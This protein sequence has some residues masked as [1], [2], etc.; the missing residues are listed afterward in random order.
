VVSVSLVRQNALRLPVPNGCRRSITSHAVFNTADARWLSADEQ[1]EEIA[2]YYAC[3]SYVD[4]CLGVMLDALTESGREDRTIVCVWGDHGM[5][6]GEHG[7]FR[8]ATVFDGATRVPFL[9]AAPGTAKAGAACTRPT[10]LIDMYPTLAE[11]CGLPAPAGLEG[12]SMV[13]LL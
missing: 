8:K 1:R 2:A 12:I 4:A 13:P 7:L 3:I 9:I 11:L 5:H 10:E 6:L